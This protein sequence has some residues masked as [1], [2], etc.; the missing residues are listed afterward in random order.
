MDNRKSAQ[1][2]AMPVEPETEVKSSGFYLKTLF[3]FFILYMAVA[4][5]TNGEVNDMIIP[6]TYI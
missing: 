5:I 2:S 4:L 3:F 6:K 1:A